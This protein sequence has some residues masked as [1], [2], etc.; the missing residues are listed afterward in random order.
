MS[1]S[2]SSDSP[3]L[4][5]T[6]SANKLNKSDTPVALRTRQFS[7]QVSFRRAAELG[8]CKICPARFDSPL[9]LRKH[10][11]NHK[12]NAKRRKALEA[13]DSLYHSTP[14]PDVSSPTQPRTLF[15][16]FKSSFPELFSQEMIRNPHPNTIFDS[17]AS[18]SQIV[19]IFDPIVSPI[20]SPPIQ[21]DPQPSSSPLQNEIMLTLN[22]LINSV[23][24]ILDRP[25]FSTSGLSPRSH[26]PSIC[27]PAETS[28]TSNIHVQANAFTLSPLN[29]PLNSTSNVHPTSSPIRTSKPTSPAINSQDASLHP[30]IDCA[31]VHVVPPPASSVALSPVAS[32]FQDTVSS[33]G[34]PAE[35]SGM[36]F[37]NPKPQRGAHGESSNS[38]ASSELDHILNSTLHDSALSPEIALLRECVSAFPAARVSPDILEMLLTS[39]QD[40][41]VLLS[42]GPTASPPSSIVKSPPSIPAPIEVPAPPAFPKKSYAQA[43]KKVLAKCPFCEKKFYSQRTC[44]NHIISI[45]NPAAV[46]ANQ[47]PKT[48]LP[49]SNEKCLHIPA[50]NQK[51]KVTAPISNKSS[52]FST[53]VPPT[54]KTQDPPKVKTQVPP[55]SSSNRKSTIPPATAYHRKILSLG[56]L[57]KKPPSPKFF[58][59]L[60]SYKF[61]CRHCQE[62]F[63]S[64]QS[65][66]DHIK[67]NHNLL[68]NFSDQT[69]HSKI[70]SI[71]APDSS[72][73]FNASPKPKIV[74]PN[75][76]VIVPQVEDHTDLISPVKAFLENLYIPNPDN[77]QKKK[78]IKKGCLLPNI[79][80]TI[81]SNSS[82]DNTPPAPE[83]NV[84]AE[85]HNKPQSQPSP[86]KQCNL[87][88]FVARKKAGLRLHFYKEHRFQIIPPPAHLAD[89]SEKI[90]VLPS[91]EDAPPVTE[92]TK[93]PKKV[94]FQISTQQDD[95]TLTPEVL[96]PAPGFS[97]VDPDFQTPPPRR[98][99][100]SKPEVHVPPSKFV[101]FDNNTLKFS[102]PLQKKL[103]CPVPNCSASFGTKLWYLTNSS[104]KKHL[105]VFHKSKPSK[106][107]FFCTICSSLIKKLPSKHQCLINNLVLPA[108]PVD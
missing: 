46:T 23:S 94:S 72:L 104:I 12:S 3:P 96:P 101:S 32:K 44:D 75:Q 34:S 11:I 40:S 21:F 55:K 99:F 13:I 1:D 74:H 92:I 16:K 67:T 82:P 78:L 89:E 107:E 85:I 79:S 9:R 4:K 76:T 60:P 65:L 51:T 42:P 54:A 62:F 37:F 33:S 31:P 63:P 69:F 24:N 17:E 88:D 57:E 58:P 71:P 25:S 41:D 105:T 59:K 64:D 6:E 77:L 83:I 102:F 90:D 30:P 106:V 19:P 10:V 47:P 70:V 66:A 103:S 2:S 100:H 56:E 97:D 15:D 68:L 20:V 29:S 86:P 50:K 73:K 27:N 5:G 53:K 28:S 38:S 49:P 7:S 95:S 8:Q 22:K 48:E 35:N 108:D 84:S 80:K 81:S 18:S 93:K 87:C 45:H 61:F 14:K 36:L 26:H 52:K 91:Q 39:T 98:Q 43:L